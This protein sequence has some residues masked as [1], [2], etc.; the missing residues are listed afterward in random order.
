MKKGSAL[1]AVV[2]V[3]LLGFAVGEAL[4][5]ADGGSGPTV[6]ACAQKEGGQLRQVSA[7]KACR[8][9][10]NAVQWNQQGP[11]GP[12]GPPGPPG[13]TG[14]L[15]PIGFR[16]LQRSGTLGPGETL[17]VPFPCADGEVVVSGG[18]IIGNQQPTLQVVINAPF[19]DG[20]HSGWRVDLH[21]IS[22]QVV[23]AQVRVNQSCAEGT[24][25]GQ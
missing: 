14:K 17:V 19:F 6:F 8:P 18:Y 3:L 12:P 9:S 4:A 2:V 10:E 16:D 22:D 20:T 21:N 7:A 25:A 15:G 1:A 23:N 24:G 13:P 11:A 5:G